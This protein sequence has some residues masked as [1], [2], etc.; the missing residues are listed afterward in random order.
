LWR[1]LRSASETEAAWGLVLLATGVAVLVDSLFS[2]NFVMPMS[3]LWIALLGGWMLAWWRHLPGRASVPAPW[4]G[5]PAVV[6]LVTVQ[7]WLA[8]SIAPEV[9][10]WPQPLDEAIERY[11]NEL[12]N[13]RFWTHG[14]FGEPGPRP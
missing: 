2:G 7:I 3:Q 1:A 4:L 12:L 11:P 9:R 14:W 13:P 6:I 5:R 8:F 10:R